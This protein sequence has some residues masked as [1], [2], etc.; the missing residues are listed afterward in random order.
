MTW[1]EFY[2]LFAEQI[3]GIK[4][5]DERNRILSDMQEAFEGS[6][7]SRPEKRNQLSMTYQA[8]KGKCWEVLQ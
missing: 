2:N 8:L 1:D 7:R 4:T 6:I 3:S 5:V